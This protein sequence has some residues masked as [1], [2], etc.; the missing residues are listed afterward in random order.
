M[1]RL[2]MSVLLLTALGMEAAG[3]TPI[4]EI[5][6][7]ET[8]PDGI[9]VAKLANG[10]TIIV[11]ENHT[12]KVATV[13]CFVKNT[14]SV[15]EGK[16]L[17]AG[18]SH[19]LEHVVA[20]GSTTKRSEQEIRELVNT[21]GGNTNAYT[22][23]DVTAYYIDCPSKNVETCIELIADSMQHAAFVPEE[24]DRELEVVQQELADGLEN[25][26]RVMWK[27]MQETLY[28]ESP[29]RI[30]IIGYLD[31]LKQ[32]K[33]EQIIDFY[34]TRYTPNNQIFVVVGDVETNK[35][36]AQVAE[37]WKETPR[38]FEPDS[39]I[40][41]EPEQVAPRQATR[42]MDGEMADIT[43]AFPTVK[44]ND[45]DLFALDVLSY[46]LSEGDSSRMVRDMRYARSLVLSVTTS[47]YTPT[48][49]RG[50]FGVKMVVAPEKEQEAIAAAMEHLHKMK[51]DLVTDAEL[52]KAKKQ[53]AAELVFSRQTVQGQAESLA[54]S[55]MSTGSPRFNELYVEGIQKVTA[56]QVRE[57]AQKYFRPESLNTI[58]ILPK[59][60]SSADDL[61][62]G[63]KNAESEVR[64]VTLDNGLKVL[65]KRVSHLPL[66]DVS[67]YA[68]GGNLTD[69]ENMSGRSSFLSAMLDKGTT[70]RTSEEI[71][72]YFDSIGGVQSFSA[73][74]NTIGGH[75]FILKED[76][77]K[78]F[79]VF[80]DCVKN[81]AFPEDK[82]AQVKTLMLASIANRTSHPQSELM[83]L[84]A[85]SLPKT[86]P[87]HV[88]SGGKKEV[89]EA[90]TPDAL[91]KHYAQLLN[92]SR[93]ILTIYGDVDEAGA[94]ALA[95]KH[96]G[97]L[98][99][100]EDTKPWNFQYP[101]QLEKNIIKHKQTGKE[102]GLVLL[103]YA[104]PSMFEKE[105]HAAL[106]VLNEIMANYPGGWLF[107]ELRGEGLVYSVFGSLL[108]GA[109]P[110]YNV[111]MAQTSPDKVAEVK[112]RLFAAVEKA[113]AGEITEE[114]F[115]NA[116]Q[117]LIAS[118]A[119]DNTTVS[120]Q[121]KVQ[122]LDELYGLGYDHDKTF[123]AR[124]EE[125][126]LE[127]VRA[128]ARKYFTTYVLVSTS[129]RE[130]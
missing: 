3:E 35:V 129:N 15:N 19:V 48:F 21:F 117:K 104:A 32:V 96:F 105:D 64:F 50:F 30:P 97:D 2:F 70:T 33:R 62:E 128:V 73:G 18:L 24:F 55:Y 63:L 52:A 75:L 110:G 87:F 46:I 56:E 93:M 16:Y 41:Q 99:V 39:M 94:I 74:R 43:I 89:V 61:A 69:M 119:Q 57:V 36:L 68:L 27:M 82:F 71:D 42:T 72:E 95:K 83:E 1:Y 80:A 7:R 81:P 79:E 118:H 77:E 12:A 22:S 40:P 103:A 116:K 98:P 37:L 113:K 76:L 65:V 17:G 67:L 121:A 92:P 124:Y 100:A 45:P 126:T 60:A 23:L 127:K 25:R 10:L 34:R 85:D 26:G 108:S 59:G 8:Y 13:R 6:S 123:E 28:Q 78:S 111:F 14:G 49:V 88:V 47:S 38:G 11:Q 58:R 53:K 102:S 86:T 66:V 29:A 54:N 107:L 9:T 5:T 20:G 125:V 122:G 120:E 84:F 114:E 115:Q 51:T 109:V 130:E 106:R 4:M 112:K 91:R 101:N 90:L 44:L 31:V